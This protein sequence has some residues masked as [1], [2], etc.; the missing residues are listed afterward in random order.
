MGETFDDSATQP[1]LP[2]APRTE[3]LAAPAVDEK[4]RTQAL[5][6]EQV[7][8]RIATTKVGKLKKVSTVVLDQ[9]AYDPS[10]RFLLVAG[11]LFLVFLLLLFFSKVL[12]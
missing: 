2:A 1:L 4:A 11:L 5:T 8:A 12:G 6:P 9:A 3:A 10:L 7:K